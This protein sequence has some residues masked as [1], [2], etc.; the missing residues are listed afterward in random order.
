[1][2]NFEMLVFFVITE[3]YFVFLQNKNKEER[4]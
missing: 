2:K 4:L 1:M 3:N